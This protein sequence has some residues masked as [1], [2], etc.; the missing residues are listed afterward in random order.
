[1]WWAIDLIDSEDDE[2]EKWYEIGK[3]T[4]M[5]TIIQVRY[6]DM[7]ATLIMHST[8]KIIQGNKTSTDENICNTYTNFIL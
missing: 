6:I 3:E 1:M 8:N 5:M 2:N 4:F 7:I